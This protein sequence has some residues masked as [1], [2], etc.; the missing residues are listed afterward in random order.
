V[1][2]IPLRPAFL[3]AAVPTTAITDLALRRPLPIVAASTAAA[4]GAA[5]P[6]VLAPV[7]AARCACVAVAGWWVQWRERCSRAR[8]S[9]SP[10][11]AREAV[12]GKCQTY[13]ET[14][15]QLGILEPTASAALPAEVEAGA[16]L[17]TADASEEAAEL[18]ARTV[19]LAVSAGGGAFNMTLA[20]AALA[21]APATAALRFASAC[22]LLA[23]PVAGQGLRLAT[24]APADAAWQFT[25]PA[26]PAALLLAAI[27]L[28]AA[29][30][31][32]ATTMCA[33]AW[34]KAF[35]VWRCLAAKDGEGDFDAQ[36]RNLLQLRLQAEKRFF[37]PCPVSGWVSE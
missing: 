29:V 16:G 11:L 25:S 23:A 2:V 36:L 19:A 21:A 26:T 34:L 24:L 3:C 17:G 27:S 31:R 37:P 15:Q 4:C 32:A 33:A 5:A 30:T 20:A 13:H 10:S 6:I 28:T 9:G 18:W 7:V 8:R 22:A 12:V 35:F 1:A 14:S